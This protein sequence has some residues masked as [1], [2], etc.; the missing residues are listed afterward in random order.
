MTGITPRTKATVLKYYTKTESDS[1]YAGRV[2]TDA[3]I[4]GLEGEIAALGDT[5]VNLGLVT[6]G[7]GTYSLFS[8]V[9]L[10]GGVSVEFSKCMKLSGEQ[11]LTGSITF[12]NNNHTFAGATPTEIS[13]LSTVSSNIQTQ[14]NTKA[15]LASPAFTGNPT[16][17]GQSLATVNQIPSLTPYALL[18]T[19]AFIGVP[20]LN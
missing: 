12:T 5:L 1:N 20:T 3:S 9:V 2:S 10:G 13:H 4:A 16:L 6:G 19:P 18:D 17:G 14:L 8:S 15:P 11:T 7:V